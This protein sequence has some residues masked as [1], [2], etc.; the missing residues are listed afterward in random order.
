M[1]PSVAICSVVM[2]VFVFVLL[3]D[4][5]C[6][7]CC[8]I[9]L[10][11]QSNQTKPWAVKSADRYN[12]KFTTAAGGRASVLVGCNTFS[13]LTADNLRFEMFDS[14]DCFD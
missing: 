6:V 3:L 12:R 8:P 2:H 11:N 7:I 9:L 1:F 10:S 14:K 4:V 13:E 5:P